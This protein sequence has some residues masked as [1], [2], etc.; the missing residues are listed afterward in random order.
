MRMLRIRSLKGIEAMAEIHS[1]EGCKFGVV[2]LKY[3]SIEMTAVHFRLSYS[4]SVQSNQG[5][6]SILS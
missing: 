4:S 5:K 2:C 3:R 1:L 6:H